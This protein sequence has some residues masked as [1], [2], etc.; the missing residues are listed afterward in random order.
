MTSLFYPLWPELVLI[1]VAC[2][3]FLLGAISSATA[4]RWCPVLALAAL[5]T[6]F[7]G[8]LFLG[9]NSRGTAYA[10]DTVFSGDLA[11]YIKVL[12]SG[13]AMLFVLLSW[14]T[15]DARTGNSALDVGHEVGEFFALLLLAIA[16]IFLVASAN[17]IILLF[18]GIELASIPT[19]IMV[20]ISRPLPV[21]QEAGVK[22]FFLGAMAAAV[23]L[24]GFSYLYGTTGSTSLV[25]IRE[26]YRHSL[27]AG[28]SAWEL[29]AVIL[30][31]M[32][33][34]FKLA[35]VPLHAYAGDVY[36]GAATPVTA[37]LAFVPKTAGIVAV[38]KIL[39]VVSGGDWAPPDVI[40]K[41]LWVMAVLTMTFGNVLGL[42]QQNIK[43]IFAYSSVAH[44][45]YMLVALT[46]LLAAH[47][48]PNAA[49]IQREAIAAVLFYLCAYGIMNTGAFG[50]LMLLPGRTDT[51]GRHDAD[52]NTLPTAGSAETLEDVAGQGRR[53]IGLGLAMAVC[54]FSLTGIPLTIG[55]MGKVLLVQPAFPIMNDPS[56]PYS[57][58]MWWLVVLTMINAAVSAGYY[59][60]IVAYMFLR[61]DASES[62]I[63][64]APQ[65]ARPLFYSRPVSLTVLLSVV[66]TICFG[67]II[68]ATNALSER[69]K[70]AAKS[71]VDDDAMPANH[72]AD[73][74]SAKPAAVAEA[75]AR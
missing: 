18:L 72:R 52:G 27:A 6:V 49:E 15:N 50:V 37:L 42:I 51:H 75:A 9:G 14:P 23:M 68:P 32:G 53:H 56:H 17:D 12:A 7:A 13:V 47:G 2:I 59:L 70:V 58:M 57:H 71:I 8:I 26:H 63:A 55:F 38:I 74:K 46:A 24:F 73:N 34:A 10:Q 36:Q 30:L 25:E 22:Y 16:G 60:K 40:V 35:A 3:L 20:S 48:M 65:I 29:M 45:G 33:F 11:L 5:I 19:Y 31:L 4:R 39:Q 41:L 67:V 1:T 54:C 62:S 69:V 28:I 21:A 61:P 44:S 64:G 66:G 43:R